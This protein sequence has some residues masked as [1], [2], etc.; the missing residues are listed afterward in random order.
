MRVFLFAASLA[1]AYE[2]VCPAIQCAR[3]VVFRSGENRN[4]PY[5]YV[6][7]EARQLLTK[8]DQELQQRCQTLCLSPVA[9]KDTTLTSTKS[10][11]LFVDDLRHDLSHNL[12]GLTPQIPPLAHNATN[13]T[14]ATAASFRNDVCLESQGQSAEL[15]PRLSD[16]LMESLLNL[17]LSE[18]VFI[19][20]LAAILLTSCKFCLVP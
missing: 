11:L 17:S 1:L 14:A 2:N 10:V 5:A 9:I 7:A 4:L 13:T 19:G 18:I 8:F 20:L 3:R 12:P 6:S 15:L 16:K